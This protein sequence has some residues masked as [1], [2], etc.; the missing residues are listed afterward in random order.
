MTLTIE[1]SDLPEPSFDILRS[2]IRLLANDD[3]IKLLL[4][5]F[6]PPQHDSD[7]SLS[8]YRAIGHDTE[9]LV[10]VSVK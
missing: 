9:T 10:R 7:G 2:I 8:L 3:T 4:E 1:S 5:C 6:V